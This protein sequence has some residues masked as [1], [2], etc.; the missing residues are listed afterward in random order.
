MGNIPFSS[1]RGKLSSFS[2]PMGAIT[3]TEA[4]KM[5]RVA[6]KIISRHGQNTSG[7][8]LLCT[9]IQKKVQPATYNQKSK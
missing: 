7:R 6:T 8:P 2:R 3:I 1:F 4:Q 9:T 5:P